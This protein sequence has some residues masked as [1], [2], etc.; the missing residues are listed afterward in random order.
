LIRGTG[1]WRPDLTTAT[2]R[3]TG[4]RYGLPQIELRANSGGWKRSHRA[5][6]YLPNRLAFRSFGPISQIHASLSDRRMTESQ[7]PGSR[8]PKSYTNAE[9]STLFAKSLSNYRLES[10]IFTGYCKKAIVP[11]LS[12]LSLFDMRTA[13]NNNHRDH[14]Q[15]VVSFQFLQG[16]KAITGGKPR[17]RIIRS[18]MCFRA[19]AI[20]ATPSPEKQRRNY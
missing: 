8:S 1:L 5:Q 3:K 9:E 15:S 6:F 13:G 19:S 17:S 20:L 12:A 11:A 2:S 7:I 10:G 14:R 4:G 16:A 18:A